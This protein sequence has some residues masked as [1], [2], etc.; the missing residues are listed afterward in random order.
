V[1]S[2]VRT[3][4]LLAFFLGI[5]ATVTGADAAGSG[6]S[7]GNVAAAYLV[8]VDGRELWTR[9]A[10]TPLPPASLTKLMT[11]LLV[12]ER[13]DLRSV[14]T[15]STDA[16]RETGTAIGLAPGDRM[17]VLELLAA[18]VIGS[19]N[20]ACHVLADHVAGS[21]TKFVAL[22]NARA[23][24]MGL[25]RTRFANACGHD[26]TGMRSTARDLARLA[27]TAM[28]N[29]VFA[30]MAGVEESWIATA[31]AGK[32]FPL[33]NSN[34]LIGRYRGAIGVKTGFTGAAGKCLVAFAER[35]GKRVLLVLL[36]APD[37]WWKAEEI[38]D[39]AFARGPA[40]SPSRP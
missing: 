21:E 22:M 40:A 3:A 14:A 9:N 39:A 1:S 34:L 4:L 20:D 2:P 23:R 5:V 12:L 30:K 17:A 26:A 18:T 33:R 29:P 37:R 15:V 31:D 35:G 28:G 27:E 10:D 8:K 38:L 16:S 6:D 32:R 25:S 7:F 11:A 19:A 13:A 36:N 24:K